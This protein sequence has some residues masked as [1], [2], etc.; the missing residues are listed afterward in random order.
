MDCLL[1]YLLIPASRAAPGAERQSRMKSPVGAFNSLNHPPA[2]R[3]FA[4]A[5]PSRQRW[6]RQ[7]PARYDRKYRL[8]LAGQRFRASGW[9]LLPAIHSNI[10]RYFIVPCFAHLPWRCVLAG[11]LLLHMSPPAPK[12]HRSIA[13][14]DRNFWAKPPICPP[15]LAGRGINRL[16]HTACGN[17]MQTRPERQKE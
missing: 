14:V 13:A 11:N 5:V 15:C 7:A 16:W 3:R 12:L 1:G 6:Q 10:P 2:E 17:T 4:K 8:C 9:L